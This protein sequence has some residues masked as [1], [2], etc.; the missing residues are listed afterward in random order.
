MNSRFAALIVV[1][2]VLCTAAVS[3]A[4]HGQYTVTLKTANLAVGNGWQY[5]AK[6]NEFKM[7]GYSQH[8]FFPVILKHQA[9]TGFAGML[10]GWSDEAIAFAGIKF[11]P[12]L[13]KRLSLTVDQTV[14][15]NHGDD[16]L[17]NWTSLEYN[18]AINGTKLFFG[19]HLEMVKTAGIA[20]VWTGIHV[21]T[22]NLLEIG[23]YYHSRDNWAIRGS[24]TIL[25]Q[26]PK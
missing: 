5:S 11:A 2:L 12:D 19:P 14:I 6:Y 20:R 4:D 3:T 16:D 22:P 10:S 9:V 21:G 18:T 15:S 26:W 23:T 7:T 13:N 1:V 8:W 24:L 25:L 17:Y